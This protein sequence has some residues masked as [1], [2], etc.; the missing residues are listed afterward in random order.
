MMYIFFSN[1]YGHFEKMDF[2]KKYWIVLSVNVSVPNTHGHP[3]FFFFFFFF[4]CL[5]VVFFCCFLFCFF[6]VCFLF[7][8][9]LLLL[10]FV[11]LSFFFFSFFF[12]FLL[13]FL[14]LFFVLLF[15]VLLFFCCCFLGG[16][17]GG[18]GF[19]VTFYKFHF[20]SIFKIFRPPHN[21]PILICL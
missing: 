1:T 15:F 10:S 2:L 17:S 4:F 16:G 19:S 6:F 14:V 7:V 11:V 12:F 21:K 5:F 20:S 3:I 18:R 9:L 13:F 8:F